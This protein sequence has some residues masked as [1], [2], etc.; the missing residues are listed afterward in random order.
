MPRMIMCETHAHHLRPAPAATRNPPT[1]ASAMGPE[2]PIDAIAETP[3]SE[4]LA[5]P[6]LPL[7]PEP[8][9]PESEDPEPED[10]LCLQLEWS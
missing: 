5:P 8:E 2:P 10:L 3:L 7:D 4:V 6:E 1:L 9:D